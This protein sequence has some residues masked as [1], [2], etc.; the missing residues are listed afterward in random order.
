MLTRHHLRG[1]EIHRIEARSAKAID[2]HAGNRIAITGSDHAGARDVSACLRRID[3]AEHDVVD[4]RSFKSVTVLD[5]FQRCDG[6]TSVDT[7]CSDPS[8]LPRRAA[9]AR[10]RNVSVGHVTPRIFSRCGF[11]TRVTPIFNRR[12][13]PGQNISASSDIIVSEP[14]TMRARRKLVSGNIRS[15]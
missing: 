11:R 15:T 1:G 7:S 12:G 6:K 9:C 2:L 14:E 5:G 3:A 13:S 10:R 4:F 8:A